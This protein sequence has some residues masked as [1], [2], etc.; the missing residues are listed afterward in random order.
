MIGV[1]VERVSLLLPKPVADRNPLQMLNAN[2]HFPSISLET[3]GGALAGL[4]AGLFRP[5]TRCPDLTCAEVHC[6]SL[7]GGSC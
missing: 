7:W 2:M 4:A 6:G 3:L 1:L 5:A